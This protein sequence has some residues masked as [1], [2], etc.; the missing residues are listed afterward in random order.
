MFSVRRGLRRFGVVVVAFGLDPRKMLR[1]IIFVPFFVRDLVVFL[2]EYARV[3]RKGSVAVV[4]V[5]S[6]RFSNSGIARGHYFHQDL[7]AARH[8]F[9]RSP[10]RHVDVGS[11][12]DGFIAH[13]LCF[14]AVEVLDIRR[15]DSAISGLTFRQAD[16]MNPPAELIEY[17]DSVSCLHALEHF[18]LGRYGDPLDFSGWVKGLAALSKLL[19]N[20]GFL[21]LSVPVGSPCIEFNAQRIFSPSEIVD[22]ARNHGLSLEEFSYVDDDGEFRQNGSMNAAEKLDYGCG[23]YV[24]RKLESLG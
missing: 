21:Y 15:L 4:P 2:F 8:V 5:L 12:I 13:L 3:D 24:F 22:V 1:G 14:R 23:C 17:A 20:G 10:A 19:K 9:A 7:W 6:D 16:M 11:R 18:G